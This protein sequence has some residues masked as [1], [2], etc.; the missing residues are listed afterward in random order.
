MDKALKQRL[1]GASVII[2]LA[3][4]V[5]PMMLSGRPGTGPQESQKIELPP[6]PGELSFET[7]RF[8]VTDPP[9]DSRPVTEPGEEAGNSR[10]QV[11]PAP[12]VKAIER[13]PAEQPGEEQ[14]PPATEGQ[15]EVASPEP[16]QA[17]P[18]SSPE[19]VAEPESTPPPVAADSSSTKSQV[20]EPLPASTSPVT[21]SPT[22]ANTGR[23]VVQVASL[24]SAENASRLM[25]S[26]RQKGFPVLK[27][28]IESDVGTLNR[29]RVGPYSSEV[30]AARISAR[31]GKEMQGVSPRVLDLQPEQSAPVT[32]PADPLVRWVVQVGSFSN[33]SNAE[34]LV[35]QL[36]ADGLSA[37]QETRTSSGSPI[38]RVRVGPF[39]ERDEALRIRQKLSENSSIDGV[40][41][42]AD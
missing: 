32:N 7:R 23:Y 40:V 38:F 26:L 8:P 13:P 28:V 39:L 20:L 34:R 29:V 1:V 25:L 30:E 2:A 3:V 31:I 37:Y 42:S 41:M 27:D 17:P 4:V 22:I 21:P 5:L 6:K 14:S 18:G 10:Q 19:A 15:E 24:G 36:R 16:E 35:K 33:A 11:F 12:A 9:G